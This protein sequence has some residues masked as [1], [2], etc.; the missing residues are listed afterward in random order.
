MQRHTNTIVNR[1]KYNFNFKSIT[2]HIRNAM[3]RSQYAYTHTIFYY[4]TLK[5][6]KMKD[7][8]SKYK[9]LQNDDTRWNDPF[10]KLKQVA[11]CIATK[12]GSQNRVHT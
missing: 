2:L 10:R 3:A 1:K 5:A 6:I 12:L 4:N 7:D 11:R 9:N 8:N